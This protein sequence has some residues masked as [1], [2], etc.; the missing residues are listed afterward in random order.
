MKS[1]GNLDLTNNNL[2]Q[3][4]IGVESSFPATASPGRIVFSNKKLYIC[5]EIANNQ[6][7]WVPLTTKLDTYTHMQQTASSTWTI[8]HNL[9]TTTPLVQ[10]YGNDN[11]MLIPDEIEIIDQNTVSVD[12]GTAIVGRAV[13]MFGDIFGSPNQEI[14]TYEHT[15]TSVATTWTI[16]HNLGGYPGV[17]VFVG[18]QEILPASITHTSNFQTVITFSEPRMGVARLVL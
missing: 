7:V 14:H 13:V 3:F 4:G 6:P 2:L 15:Q 10:I 16:N 12:L 17:R 1:Y 11:R 5:I 9:N 18:N 8:V